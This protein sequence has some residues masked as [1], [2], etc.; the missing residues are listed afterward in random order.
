MAKR[1]ESGLELIASFPWPVG[2]VLGIVAYVAIRYGVGWY[3]S[4]VN[5]PLAQSFG[6]IASSGIYTPI[7]WFVL[8]VCW[9]G[10]I[11]SFVRRCHRKHLLETQTGLDSLRKMSWCEFEMLVG[12]A[13][14]RQGYAVSET[15]LGGPDGGIDLVLRKDGKNT[16]VQCKQW[17]TQRVDVKVVREMFGLLMDRGAAAVKIVAIGDYTADARRFAKGKAIELISGE[18]LL[19]MVREVQTSTTASTLPA[20][21]SFTKAV[22][23]QAITSTNPTCPNCESSMIKRFN[24][25]TQEAFWGCVKY[26]SCR[27]TKAVENQDY[28]SGS[29]KSSQ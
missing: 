9:L 8:A 1:K 27:G 20:S 11:I 15:G 4:S 16:L 12:E 29:T 6:K 22:T 14:R 24:R 28:L 5:S 2:F 13:F 23:P 3:M 10:A 17:K 19:T 26:P 21:H 18:T 25:K 7:A